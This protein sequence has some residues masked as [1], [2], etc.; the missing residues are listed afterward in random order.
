MTPA[1]WII[2]AAAVAVVVG[3]LAA[4]RIRKKK[5]KTGCGGSGAPAVPT[6]GA[7]EKSPPTNP[8]PIDNHRP[9]FG[10]PKGG[11]F[12]KWR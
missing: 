12:V 3:S 11:R 7:A 6:R 2:L 1:D 10:R 8:I 4:W 9:P 5:G